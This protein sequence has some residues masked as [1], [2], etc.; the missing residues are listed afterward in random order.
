MRRKEMNLF[1]LI[2]PH[3]SQVF[4]CMFVLFVTHSNGARAQVSQN[5]LKKTMPRYELGVRTLLLN[6]PDY[7]GS[8]NNKYRVVPFP[9]Y[10]YR[11]DHLRA[12]DEGTRARFYTSK[13]HETGIS[14]TF[15]FP[16]TS[17]TDSARRE[18]PDLDGLVA[19]GPR[20]LLRII[21]GA[22]N[23]KFNF[24]LATR[25]VF[26]SKFSFNNLLR[27]Q[28]FSIEPRLRYWNRFTDTK[29]TFYS[30]LGFEFGSAK[31]S[32]YFYEVLPIYSTQ[33]R[34][35]YQARA[36]LIETIVA[37]GVGQAIHPQLYLLFDASWRN[38]DWSANKNS[39][40]IETHNNLGVSIGIVWT[41]YESDQTVRSSVKP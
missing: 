39:P 2:K 22:S 38:L 31:Y 6:L 37:A 8:N 28:G 24:S 4:T 13:Y 32:R 27:D 34:P 3:L 16:V 5:F 29:T 23:Q 7:P 33:T 9:H 10:I 19:I 25:A 17:T 30:S 26:S 40:L 21:E 15:N 20:I 1:T 36:G 12:D 11:G 18:M 35:R 41:F 14:F